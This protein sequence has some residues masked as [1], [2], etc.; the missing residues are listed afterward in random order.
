MSETEKKHRRRRTSKRHKRSITRA[1]G[2]EIIIAILFS[3][4]VFLLYEDME[5]KSVVFHGVLF[6]FQTINEWFSS[7]INSILGTVNVVETSDI[8]GGFLLLLAWILFS[9]RV[10]QKTIAR[11]Y[12]LSECPECGG[13]LMHVHRNPLQR[14]TAKIFMVQVRRY[15]CKSCDFDGLRI[16]SR[17]TRETH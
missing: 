11:Y 10:R 12:E 14:L 17:D 5:V 15:R 6:I 4:G 1:Y 16:R 13:I 3:F 2:I 7:F 8:I 9:F